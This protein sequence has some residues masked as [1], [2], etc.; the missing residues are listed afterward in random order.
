M[1]TMLG[2]SLAMSAVI[3]FGE[4]DA[5]TPGA[6]RVGVLSFLIVGSSA[7]VSPSM[8]MGEVCSTHL[9]VLLAT[10][11]LYSRFPTGRAKKAAF[12]LAGA[13]RYLDAGT[14]DRCAMAVDCLCPIDEADATS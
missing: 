4:V 7:V 14:S 2:A 11:Q 5:V 8:S 13:T 6:S 10:A 9:T 1:R 12:G 3:G